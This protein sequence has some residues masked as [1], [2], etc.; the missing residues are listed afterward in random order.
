MSTNES[1]PADASP[2][3]Y[4]RVDETTYTPTVHVQGAWSPHEQHMAPVGGL[5]VHA[6]ER[7][8]PR[9]HLQLAKV[10]FEIL[11]QIAREQTTVEVEVVRPGRTIELV[12][13]RLMTGGRPV[14]RATAWRLVRT[15]TAVVAGTPLE[16]MPA[17]EAFEEWD[18]A[19]TWPGG[20]IRSLRCRRDPATA[21]GRGRTWLRSDVDLVEGEEASAYAH[22][23]RLVDTANGIA[24]RVSPKEWM[25]PNTDLSIHLFRTPVGPWVGF[26]TSVSFG[27]SGVGLTSSTLHD[28]EGPLGRAEQILTVRPMPSS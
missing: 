26:D 15:D 25:F 22:F 17:P 7:H 21:P 28:V 13:A 6:I 4:E 8:E 2:A 5:L 12:E 16:P 18:A 20:Y 3:Y 23:C 27:P 14:V 9:E 24:T 1:R 10:T 19:R 11:G